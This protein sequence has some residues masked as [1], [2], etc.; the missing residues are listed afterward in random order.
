MSDLGN[1][2]VF[3]SNLKKY[4]DLHNIDRNHLCRELGFKY[5]TVCEWLSAKKYPRIDKIELLA[6][7]FN[8]QKSDLIES[9]LN[10]PCNVNIIKLAGRDG[11]FRERKLTDDQLDLFKK[12]IDQMPDAEDL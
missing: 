1:K 11:S 9:P 3:A 7:Y 4:M 8:I 6:N 12:M 5:T 10:N 2:L